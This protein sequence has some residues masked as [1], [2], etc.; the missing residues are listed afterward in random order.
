MKNIYLSLLLFF[1]LTAITFAQIPAGYYDPAAGLT[2]DELKAALHNIIKN[3]TSYPY[4]DATTDVWDILKES[5]RDPNNS[6]NVILIY[7]G[8]SVNAAQE[9]NNMNGWSR[10]HV[11]AKSHGDFGENPPAG[12][13]AHHL[14]PADISVNSARGEKDFDNGGIQHAE[15]T[16]CYTDADSWEPRPAVKGDVARMMFYMAT[17]YEGDVAGEPDLELVNYTGTS[18]PIFGKIS[19]LLLWNEQDPVDEFERNRNEVV[20][21]YQHNRNPFVDHPEYVN[22]ILENNFNIA[23]TISSIIKNPTY[24]TINDAV[25]VSTTI[26]DYDGS[27]LSVKLLWGLVSESLDDT[28]TMSVSDGTTYVTNTDI[29]AQAGGVKVYFKIEAMD[30][31]SAVTISIVQNYTVIIPANIPPVI[32]NIQYT[33]ANPTNLD[34][35]LISATITDSDGTISSALLKWKIGSESTIYEKP[36]FLNESKYKAYIPAQES[37][38]TIYFMII[39]KDDDNA[40]TTY[41]EGSYSIVAV[42][43]DDIFKMNNLNIYPNP[44][45]DKLIIKSS[46]NTQK[47]VIVLYDLLGQVI[48]KEKVQN[49]SGEYI[50]NFTDKPKGCYFINIRINEKSVTKKIIVN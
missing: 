16:E 28:I 48:H 4:T 3:H 1:F 39:A 14:R 44:V 42:S 22:L 26:T 5:D 35:V 27:I 38:K 9:Y 12:T 43:S 2:G 10:E 45:I 33:P 17:R 37:G 34:S 49:Y 7:T 19:T 50:I 41:L 20:Y 47:M 32:S 8:W 21:S 30:N 6:E 46:D 31:D 24:P 29:P 18:G 13:D 15:A 25:R 36:M 23:P 40:E 11:W